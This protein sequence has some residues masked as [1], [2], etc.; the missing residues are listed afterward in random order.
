MLHLP[1]FPAEALWL[2]RECIIK[3]GRSASSN[4]TFFTFPYWIT[5]LV[6]CSMELHRAS[7]I[8]AGLA[9]YFAFHLLWVRGTCASS[10]P[11]PTNQLTNQPSQPAA[12]FCLFID[13][14]FYSLSSSS[15]GNNVAFIYRSS[16]TINKNFCSSA[17]VLPVGNENKGLEGRRD[18]KWIVSHILLFF[19]VDVDQRKILPCG[20]LDNI[21]LIAE[22]SH[23]VGRHPGRKSI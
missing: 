6:L 17:S 13:S 8:S 1:N 15:G 18:Q 20:W 5:K 11:Y 2:A 12:S 19:F 22:I 21:E 3:S 7:R 10:F 14:T 4:A 16:M 23:E 9:V